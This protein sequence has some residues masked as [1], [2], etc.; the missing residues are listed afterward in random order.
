MSDRGAPK[1][2]QEPSTELDTLKDELIAKQEEII[3]DLKAGIKSMERSSEGWLRA[4]DEEI[5][6]WHNLYSKA[7]EELENYIPLCFKRGRENGKMARIIAECPTCTNHL[8][9][10]ELKSYR[11][12]PPPSTSATSEGSKG[13]H[14]A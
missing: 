12:A 6:F 3:T 10:A 8:H 4:K 9:R 13:K 2:K 1:R 11:R 7:H 14:A 5:K